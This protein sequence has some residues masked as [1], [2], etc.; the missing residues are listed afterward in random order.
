MKGIPNPSF[1]FLFFI[2][3]SKIPLNSGASF[4]LT[5]SIGFYIPI[6][7]QGENMKKSMVLLSV[8][9]VL[10]MAFSGCVDGNDPAANGTDTNTSEANANV[11]VDMG[12]AD[13][14]AIDPAPA[15]FEYLASLSLSAEDIKQDYE[16]ENVSGILGG[17]EGM[18]KYS[19]GNDFYVDVLEFEDSTAA[20][21]LI[22]E[23]KSSFSPLR[24]GSRF[25]EE[26]FNGHFATKITEYSTIGGEQVP[27]YS[28]IW[29]H[30][31]YVFVVYGNTGD[32][33]V[34]KELAE[35]T[36]Y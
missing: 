35:A 33:S 31:N 6:K 14:S 8:L 12:T 32:A 22:F 4:K 21:E 23:Y 26:S 29:Q 15:G 3:L 27:R 36:G 28:Y 10:M 30:E 20:E 7:D 5:S 24:T 17:S 25:V 13:M 2:A 11:S 1:F 9:A 19:D 16:A 34:V 18:Y